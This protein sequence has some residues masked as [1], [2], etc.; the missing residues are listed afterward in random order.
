MRMSLAWGVLLVTTCRL[1]HPES[2]TGDH[3]LMPI[4]NV[5]VPGPSE[6]E[7]APNVTICK[8][9]ESATRR[10]RCGLRVGSPLSN[11]V[12]FLSR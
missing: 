7:K 1:P 10:C 8:A 6:L 9:R 4:P 2:L 11:E 3:A 12:P 5:D